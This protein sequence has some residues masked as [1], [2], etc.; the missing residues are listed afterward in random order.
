MA[1]PCRVV[2]QECYHESI[3]T[4]PRLEFKAE[5]PIR[6]YDYQNRMGIK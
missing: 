3:Y 5:M 1:H 6:T 2:A 4:A